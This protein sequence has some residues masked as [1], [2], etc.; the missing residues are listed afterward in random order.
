MLSQPTWRNLTESFEGWAYRHGLLRQINRLEKRQLL[1]SRV[2]SSSCR[3]H[4]LTEAGRLYVLGGRDPAA[5]WSRP[6]DGRWRLV[7]FD[8]PETRSITRDRLR[9]YLQ[10]HGFGY[11]QKSVW[12]TPDPATEERA[13]FSAGPVD[14]QSM[15]FLEARPCAGETDADIVAGAW[16]FPRLNKLYVA[17]AAVLSR[18]PV[19]GPVTGTR[20]AILLQRWLRKERES[21]MEVMRHDPLLPE[22]LLPHD[23][24][25]RVSWQRRLKEMAVVGR[26]MQAFCPPMVGDIL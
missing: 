24:P 3:M 5:C 6:W 2:E 10:N 9:R 8:V 14:V 17:H 23:Y 15:V 26:Q 11:L 7:I 16:D 4:R 18:C 25:G 19:D 1:E 22:C 21:W 13:L 20:E 12:I